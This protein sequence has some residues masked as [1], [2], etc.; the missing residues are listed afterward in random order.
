MNL[1]RVEKSQERVTTIELDR[2]H[3]MNALD[4]A[5]HAE[6]QAAGSDL[7]DVAAHGI[8]NANAYPRS[9]Y[10]GEQA[11]YP[12]SAAWRA[13]EDAVEGPRAFAEKR[14]PVWKGR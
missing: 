9:G 13:S 11:G 2:P 6:L 5:M 7:Q 8:A 10:A 14:P 1:I 3:V 4:A 12:A